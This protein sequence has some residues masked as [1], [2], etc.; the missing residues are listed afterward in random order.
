MSKKIYFNG[1]VV[2]MNAN[3]PSAEAVLV[4]NGIIK[5]VGT[6]DE[7]LA[8]KTA[9]C[10]MVDLKGSTMAP[11]FIDPHSH[12]IAVAQSSMMPNFSEAT[13]IEEFM[14]ILKNTVENNA[15]TGGEWV[16][17]LGYDNSK[18][19]GEKHPTKFDLDQVS[20]EIPIFITHASGHIAAVNSK[21]L[22][23]FGYVGND[24]VVPEGGV[25][26]TVGDT[27]EPN[28]VLEESA[29]LC[30][31]MKKLIVGPGFETVIKS[32]EYAQNYYAGLGITTCQ[33]CS[34]DL[35]NLPLLKA[36]N[37]SGKLIL[38]VVGY[39]IQG[40][41]GE[42][43][44]DNKSP[45]HSY[46]K[47]LKIQGGKI[48]LDGSPQAKTAWLTKPYHEVPAGE[49]AS[50][51]GYENQPDTAVTNYLVDCIEKNIQVQ[52]HC[53]GD[54]SS[55]QFIRC[56]KK[57]LEITGN[58]TDLRPIMVH[59]QTVREDQLDEMKEI[60][61]LATFFL[62]HIF[63]W[64]DY[65]YESVLGPDRANR[66]SPA[67]S[68]LDRGI[69]FTL[70]QDAPVKPPNSLRAIQNAVERKTLSG[71]VLGEDL[72]I[73]ANDAF[74]AVTINGAYQNFEENEKGSIEENKKAD[75]VI[76]GSNPLKVKTEE[77]HA[78]EILETIKDGDTIFTK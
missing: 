6:T 52:A 51:K 53:N 44:A 17:G 7:I 23:I 15:P 28:G 4:E 30:D 75:F 77:I 29:Y 5:K 14:T 71:R 35:G 2:T 18:F 48:W 56:Y 64:G 19:A 50:Y 55:D 54:A 43:F 3:Q 61:M 73:S 49:E 45:E 72:R 62:D 59:C 67:K 11:G 20:S 8:L 16:L 63:F 32:L 41:Q 66:I 38:D 31:A 36:A 65:H 40:T 78:I 21:V 47:K 12:L 46:D 25:V 10:E 70:H 57:A 27:K 74:K 58:K 39:A 37:D 42:I 34:V 1:D 76:L 13:S 69:S 24:Y 22:E 60:G 9:D 33:D 26:Q 68:A